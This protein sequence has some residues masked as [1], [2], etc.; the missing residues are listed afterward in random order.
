MFIIFR[1]LGR[2]VLTT[3]LAVALV[4]LLVFMSGRFLQYLA[5]AARGEFAAGV[6]FIIMGYRLPEFLELILPLSFF[7]AILL[8]YG[9]MYQESEMTVLTACGVSERQ[10]LFLTLGPGLLVTAVVA[11][12][13]LWLTPAGVQQVDR[14]FTEQASKTGFEM[15][16][17]G[18]FQSIG[19]D[20]RVV[21]T[22]ALSR[23]KQ[24]LEN[25]FIAH[26]SEGSGRMSL[27]MADRGT[28]VIDEQA[29]GR[30]LVLHQGAR[31]EGRPGQADF[32]V[33][34][35]ESYGTRIETP[36]DARPR[37]SKEAV[38][39]GQLLDSEKAEQRAMLHWRVAL[40]VLVPVIT[41]LAVPLS[42][43]NPR[44]GRFFH[45]L[46][47]MVIYISYLGLLIV[48][49][50]AIASASIPGW[51]GLW[52]VHGGYLLLAVVLL[53]W[54]DW[55]LRQRGRHDAAD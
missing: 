4:L 26:G 29:E 33:T 34:T 38:G 53:F 27:M 25:V 39:T 21:Y 28:Q 47:A 24:E 3:M 40:P 16:A 50:D 23:N 41:L 52:W 14:I 1:Y 5:A 2:Q 55:R 45:L 8:T 13:S 15:L 19:S 17:P 35:F 43:V 44:Q 10:V 6:L 42:R 31:F 22:E 11:S 7:L 32:D 48:G 54:P 12:M 30:F 20:E 9:R 37:Q 36:P 18:R 46:P 49:R 51:L